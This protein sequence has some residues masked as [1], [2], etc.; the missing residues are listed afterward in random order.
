MPL[1]PIDRYLSRHS[2]EGQDWNELFGEY[3]K[4]PDLFNERY[5]G[6]TGATLVFYVSNR[7]MHTHTTALPTG[8]PTSLTPQLPTPT[9]RAIS[10]ISCP[11]S[12]PGASA[13]WLAA[14]HHSH[15]HSAKHH[16]RRRLVCPLRIP[17]GRLPTATA[18]GQSSLRCGWCAL[19]RRSLRSSVAQCLL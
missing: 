9:R 6:P 8:P 1:P 13:M 11:N 12:A 18:S 5:A 10:Y 14:A 17:S 3:E 7:T 19:D 15:S 16:T 2:E 4:M